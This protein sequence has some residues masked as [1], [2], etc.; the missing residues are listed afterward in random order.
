MTI[1]TH[2]RI[3]HDR[4]FSLGDLLVQSR[5]LLLQLCS[6]LLE[7]TAAGIGRVK[8]RLQLFTSLSHFLE[9]LVDTALLLLHLLAFLDDTGFMV[10]VFPTDLAESCLKGF[11]FSLE[12]LLSF[13][14]HFKVFKFGLEVTAF[15][16]H[17]FDLIFEFSDSHLVHLV[18]I[19]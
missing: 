6:L 4:A 9:G 1:G 3:N 11:N 14:T 8:L 16:P 2:I 13:L 19:A 5:V 12:H 18:L 17:G 10:E 7:I 15:S